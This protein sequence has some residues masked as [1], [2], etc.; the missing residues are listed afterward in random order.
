MIAILNHAASRQH[1][2]FGWGDVFRTHNVVDQGRQTRK[3]GTQDPEKCFLAK[4]RHQISESAQN[5]SVYRVSKI[6]QTHGSKNKRQGNEVTLT[7][8][9][10]FRKGRTMKS[11]LLKSL[12]AVSVFAFLLGASAV[13]NAIDGPFEPEAKS[14]S[15]VYAE[16]LSP[17]EAEANAEARFAAWQ[18]SHPNCRILPGT[19]TVFGDYWEGV[20]YYW[21]AIHFEY[22]EVQ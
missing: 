1:A 16:G 7:T 21:C 19:E 5:D 2:A 15:Q 13:A 18:D 11:A 3:A 4:N 20:H 17:A 12:V 22:V 9:P 6:E 8:K 10:F 14:V